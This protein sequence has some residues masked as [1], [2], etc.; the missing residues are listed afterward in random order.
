MDLNGIVPSR[1]LGVDLRGNLSG[2][3]TVKYWVKLGNNSGNAPETDKYKRLYTMVE[4][5]PTNEFLMTIYFDYA[6]APQIYDPVDGTLKSNNSFVGSFFFNYN[7]QNNFSLGLE[8]Y[9]KNT[10]NNYA[11]TPFNTL[12]NQT[13]NGISI[14]AWGTISPTVKLVGRFDYMDPNT[15]ADFDNK[16][17]FLF[18]VDISP[19][20][21]V[22]ITPNMEIITYQA[23]PVNGG[24][25]S[26]VIP[27]ITLYWVF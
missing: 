6:G 17:L 1:D 25:K 4:F 9:L 26:D 21:N 3:G 12:Q 18:G 16:G 7:Y 13:N 22:T 11:P 5:Q 19:D 15:D 10:Q 14:W 8:A 27:R 23:D 2:D 24:D 20:K